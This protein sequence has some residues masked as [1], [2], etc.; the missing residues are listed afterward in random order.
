MTYNNISTLI[1]PYFDTNSTLIRPYFD[2]NSVLVLAENNTTIVCIVVQA[3]RRLRQLGEVD[4]E[5]KDHVIFILDGKLQM[6]GLGNPS[7]F[8]VNCVK[9][10]FIA[11]GVQLPQ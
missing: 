3:V 10:A 9:N 7:G 6:G 8:A 5:A 11:T 4:G 2:L 1:R